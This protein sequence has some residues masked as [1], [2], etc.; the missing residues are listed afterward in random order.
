MNSGTRIP[1][2]GKSRL[3]SGAA[4]VI[5]GIIVFAAHI[6]RFQSIE[7]PIIL[8]DE[9]GNIAN[10][11]YLAGADW[12]DVI[13]RVGY[14]S[15]GSSLF[16]LPIFLA[17]NTTDH[18]YQAVV[19]CNSLMICLY[20]VFVY[21][22]LCRLY[23]NSPKPVSAALAFAAALYPSCICYGYTAMY[24]TALLLTFAFIV[25]AF[26]SFCKTG[27][28]PYIYLYTVGLGYLLMVHMRTVGVVA[29]GLLMLFKLLFDKKLSRKQLVICI[30]IAAGMFGLFL[31][32]KNY[33]YSSLWESGT[34][35][36]DAAEVANTLSSQTSKL[37]IL[38]S[39]QGI[40]NML[41]LLVGQ[42]FYFV[43]STFLLG[44]VFIISFVKMLISRIRKKELFR[45]SAR[46]NIVLF[47]GAA[48]LA[49]L[50]ISCVT[51]IKIL[52]VDQ[53]FYGRYTE[54]IFGLIMVFGF[55]Q[56]KKHFLRIREL[57]LCLLLYIIHAGATE[58]L[59]D[60]IKQSLAVPNVVSVTALYRYFDGAKFN[61]IEA[62]GFT[63]VC[64][65]VICVF[66]LLTYK[67]ISLIAAFGMSGVMFSNAM[68]FT[69]EYILPLNEV[70]KNFKELG[71][72]ILDNHSSGS[73]D[74]YSK[75]E[76][77]NL[78]NMVKYEL[79]QYRLF[80]VPIKIYDEKEIENAS[81]DVIITDMDVQPF[82]Q[83]L[84][85]RYNILKYRGEI[86]A[87]EKTDKPS[88]NI[89]ATIFYTLCT[90]RTDWNAG[91]YTSSGEEGYLICGRGQ[92]LPAG[93]YT[94]TFNVMVSDEGGE[95]GTDIPVFITDVYSAEKNV[96][97]G[98]ED[99]FSGDFKE[100]DIFQVE[101]DITVPENNTFC[102]FRIKVSSGVIMT[103]YSVNIEERKVA[104]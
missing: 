12:S 77:I 43:T 102:E 60:K 71:S 51:F 2:T 94:I 75:P 42:S 80:Y 25:W 65:A 98:K 56:I 37:K 79:L 18:L 27:A 69:D 23:Q 22:T 46:V 84:F 92:S 50:A 73:I 53:V 48:Y 99:I 103:A 28:S 89:P 10:A 61:A 100:N 86:V 11:A 93:N 104:D 14:Y 62:A 66:A 40:K 38:F 90:D 39:V 49:Q 15:Y 34:S 59:S 81:A 55:M 5:L 70:H 16:Y 83:N 85:G 95:C 58:F 97:Y 30:L 6:I 9:F 19:I 17:V 44:G 68:L 7:M 20:Y 63:I 91:S 76:N 21:L 47:I 31:L 36:K 78:D 45:F 54:Y 67:Y 4:A 35:T 1:E 87:W 72:I 82:E 88:L 26:A 41:K 33:F 57:L 13:S 24:E 32:L 101:Y 29:V 96:Q 3:I 74:Y 64:F 8:A 52:R